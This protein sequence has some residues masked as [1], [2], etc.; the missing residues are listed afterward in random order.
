M[1]SGPM[2]NRRRVMQTLPSTLLATRIRPGALL[3]SLR[4]RDPHSISAWASH[5]ASPVDHNAQSVLGLLPTYYVGLR[6]PEQLRAEP[7]AA[8]DNAPRAT[9]SATFERCIVF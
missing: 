5:V 2:P 3:S 7:A 6:T 8:S 1:G 4:L 9:S